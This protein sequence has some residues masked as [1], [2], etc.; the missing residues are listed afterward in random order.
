MA[1]PNQ[2][3]GVLN[4]EIPITRGVLTLP[5]EQLRELIMDDVFAAAHQALH[6][7][8]HHARGFDCGG[9]SGEERPEG[10]KGSGG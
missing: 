10:R 4:L 2:V 8:M 3:V 6:A 9:Y 5:F 1:K 7:A